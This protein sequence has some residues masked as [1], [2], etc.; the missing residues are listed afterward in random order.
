[1]FCALLIDLEL[2]ADISSQAEQEQKEARVEWT[3]KG[4]RLDA[5]LIVVTGLC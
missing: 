4:H 2:F 3:T 5:V 1:M